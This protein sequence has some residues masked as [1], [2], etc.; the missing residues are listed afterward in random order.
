MSMM[1]VGGKPHTLT[2][3]ANAWLIHFHRQGVPVEHAIEAIALNGDK[4][5][6]LVALAL[7]AAMLSQ[8][9]RSPEDLRI[10]NDQ[11]VGLVDRMYAGNIGGIYDLMHETWSAPLLPDAPRTEPRK[12]RTQW[13]SDLGHDVLI[14]PKNL[15]PLR[16]PSGYLQFL[17]AETR[18][19]WGRGA[20]MTFKMPGGELLVTQS[21]PEQWIALEG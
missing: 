5:P 20:K 9:E 8:K 6:G 17:G 3:V 15:E 11:F 12:T 4:Y 7:E 16:V 18:G 14:H 21:F 1:R 19:A 2:V 10:S 13:A